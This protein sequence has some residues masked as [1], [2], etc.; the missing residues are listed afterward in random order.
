MTRGPSFAREKKWRIKARIT[1]FVY[2]RDGKQFK[3]KPRLRRLFSAHHKEPHCIN[4]K[5]LDL[6]LERR[7]G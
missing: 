7:A 3:N 5:R 4:S 1:L 6:P 2:R